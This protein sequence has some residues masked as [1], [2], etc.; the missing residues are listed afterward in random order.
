MYNDT[1]RLWRRVVKEGYL[2]YPEVTVDYM[3][4]DNASL[5]IILNLSSL[6]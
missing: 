5:Q 2:T 3:Y 6:M 1:S 4:A